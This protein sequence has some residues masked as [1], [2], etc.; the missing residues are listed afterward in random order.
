V[1]ASPPGAGAPSIRAFLALPLP[2]DLAGPAEEV[3]RALRDRLGREAVRWV[4]PES[5]HLTVRFFGDL[6]PAEVG[7]AR[8]VIDEVAAMQGFAPMPV[9]LG[10][11]SA[12]PSPARPQVLWLGVDSGGI[13]E[14]FVIHLEALLEKA[15]FGPP[16]KPWKS[17]L[18][19]GRVA[20]GARLARG[21]ERSVSCPGAEGRLERIALMR[22]EL[23]PG[24]ARYTVVAVAAAGTGADAGR[25]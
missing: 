4:P 12:F 16:D 13:V 17:H 25:A 21:W 7:R 11:L 14:A 10:A 15:G 23:G 19:L 5:F 18:T 8:A 24:G 3:Q 6:G 1:K 20:R 22:S 9:R 2:D